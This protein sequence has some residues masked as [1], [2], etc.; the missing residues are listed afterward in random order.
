MISGP[1][2]L[3]EI[4]YLTLPVDSSDQAT[5]LANYLN[6]HGVEAVS[7]TDD[8]VTCPIP[9]TKLVSTIHQLH[10]SWRLFWRHSD[11]EVFGLSVYV[12]PAHYSSK[13]VE[14]AP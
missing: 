1:E 2:S 6:A 13:C 7:D 14:E 9:D 3:V 4:Y 10:T 12:K 5:S 8:G 11:E